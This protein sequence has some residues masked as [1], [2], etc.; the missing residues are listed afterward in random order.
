VLVAGRGDPV[1]FLHGA[2]GLI[3]DPF[4]EALSAGHTVYAVEH[5]GAADADALEQLRGIWELVLFYDELLDGLGLTSCRWSATRSAAW[6][7]RSSPPTARAGSPGW[8]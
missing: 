2:G 3:W 5:P 8:C 4:L 7:P 1:L 6:W